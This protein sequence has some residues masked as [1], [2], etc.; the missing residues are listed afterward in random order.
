MNRF[1]S[2]VYVQH[3]DAQNS[4][5]RNKIEKNAVYMCSTAKHFEKLMSS[6]SHLLITW[7]SSSHSSIVAHPPA[8][9]MYNTCSLQWNKQETGSW[10]QSGCCHNEWLQLVMAGHFSVMAADFSVPYIKG[11]ICKHR[12]W[13]KWKKSF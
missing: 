9:L 13:L 3:F 2:L 12:I 11:K 8:G 4:K 1:N 10:K 6:I 5:K 7:S